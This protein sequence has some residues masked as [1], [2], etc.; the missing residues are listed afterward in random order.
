MTESSPVE[1]KINLRVCYFGTYRA[2]YN[3][4][5]MMIAGL[6]LNGVMVIE[7]HETLWHGI[8]DRIETTSGGWR[9]PGFWW[10]ILKTYF[11]LLKRYL[12][13]EDYDILVIGYPGQFDVFLARMLAWFRR[14]P[15]AMDVF[16][17]IHLIALERGLGANNKF[18]VKLLRLIEWIGLRLPD[19]LI[20]DTAEYVAWFVSTYNL[21]PNRFRIVPT[22]A[23]DRIFKPLQLEKKKEVIFQVI[24]YGTFIP[25]HGVKFI[26]EAANILRDNKEIQFV[27]IGTGP[28]KEKADALSQEYRL[29]NVAF[30]DWLDQVELIEEMAQSD[31]CLGAFGT[32]PQSIMTVQNKIYEGLAMQRPV[33]T[34]NSIAVRQYFQHEQNIF[35]CDRAS[36]IS[37]AKAIQTL[38]KDPDLRLQIA[39]N[40]YQLYCDNF[41]LLQNGIRY[42]EHLRKLLER[43]KKISAV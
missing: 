6:R 15:L 1:R 19:L 7:C 10:R 24:Y 4:N 40:G 30:I 20:Q 27:F 33:I 37:L 42:S 36:G 28:D 9:K 11:G 43:P 2:N 34:G 38:Q 16:M 29:Q 14:K 39:K 23:D 32:T 8:D 17:S 31:I 25:N 3:R 41:S 22:G 12:Q 26:I 21:P 35:L 13:I 18:T 5:Q